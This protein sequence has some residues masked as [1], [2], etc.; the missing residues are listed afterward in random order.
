MKRSVA[1]SVRQAA[2]LLPALGLLLA[3]VGA[4]ARQRDDPTPGT[5]AAG[6]GMGG[7]GGAIQELNFGPRGT[8]VTLE[9]E[10]GR[11]EGGQERVL[12]GRVLELKGRT[13]Y[14]ER[15]GV[16]VPL[17]TSGLRFTKE[18]KVGQEII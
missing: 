9:R 8:D 4:Q 11:R 5:Q 12:T 6:I 7:R 16:V 14:V 15:E 13:L 10:G 1:Q 2:L 17:D 3:P 18:P